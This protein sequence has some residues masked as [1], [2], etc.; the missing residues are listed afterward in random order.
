MNSA[1]TFWGFDHEAPSLVIRTATPP[2]PWAN[3]L[4]NGTYF[5]LITQTGGGYSF[6]ENCEWGRLTRWAPANYLLDQPGRWVYIRD[7]ESGE[8]WTPNFQP[9]R[10]GTD[11]ECRHGLASTQ[12]SAR[13]DGVRAAITYAVMA[14]KERRE[15]WLVEI[16]NESGRPRQLRLFPTIVWQLGH[17]FSDLGTANIMSLVNRG[18]FD[19]ELQAIRVRQEP[20]GNQPWPYEGYFTSSLPIRSWQTDQEFLLGPAG[21]WA[22]PKEIADG[23]GLSSPQ[24]IMGV[25]MVAC[26]EH[27]VTI[28]PGETLRFTVAL[29]EGTPRQALRPA[30]FAT[31]LDRTQEAMYRHYVTDT[32]EVETPS[33]ALNDI[34]NVWL[35]RQVWMNNYLGR[36]ATLY[37]EGGGEL[38][39]RNTAQDAWGLVPIDAKFA[40]DRLRHLCACQ[41]ESGKPLPGWSPLKGPS[42]HEPPSDF[43]VWL[44]MLALD[45]VKETG[46]DRFLQEVIPFFDGGTA[47]IYE[48]ILRAL[49]FLHA[50]A[51]SPR[52]LPLMGTQ[53]W[54]D[55]FDR[56]GAG[57]KGESVWLAMA[58]C[59]ALRQMKELAE[60][61]GDPKTAA[62]CE[63]LWMETREVVNRYAWDG[64]WYLIAFD[65]NGN[66][67][68]A[69]S[70]EEGSIHLNVQTWAILSGVARG[71][72]AQQLLRVI[73][74][75]LETPY[76][77]VLHAPPYTK[78]NPALG[79]IS[80]FAAGT[81]ENAA[82]FTHAGAF[83]I[84]ADLL[85]GRA[86]DAWK[87]FEQLLPNRDGR[88]FSTYLAEPHIFAEYT[89]GPGNPRFGEGA[90]T[91]LTG[92][93]DWL[94]RALLGRIIGLEPTWDG[95]RLEPQLPSAWDVVRL[96]RKWRGATYNVTV[97]RE[98]TSSG[99]IELIVDGVALAAGENLIPP[100]GA[101]GTCEVVCTVPGNWRPA[102]ART[103]AEAE[104]PKR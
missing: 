54:N 49:D 100:I 1:N 28:A 95:L 101:G 102:P 24:E 79:R 7:E 97:H 56:V 50:R 68:G 8:L 73:D 103:H 44:P 19:A 10:K 18:R 87:T 93:A 53:D 35:K 12:L 88:D 22:A 69:R 5:C 33:K 38:G 74:E 99:Q 70:N 34:A 92:S 32:Y 27:G 48:H 47:T 23:K 84:Y 86:D 9:C 85:M 39:Y 2:R 81:K 63:Q 67:V 42:T 6:F 41:R 13:H 80:A 83:K 72:R 4:T 15:D 61:V 59:F 76:G 20:W 3:Y 46:D 26:L 36:S 96:R 55:A 98:A 30:A 37:H 82:V 40:T 94:L 60:W 91:W 57:G 62:H 104:S 43:P 17:Y 52:G 89:I 11:F 90:F 21:S 58:H 29:G 31:L 71:E 75:R 66:P 16:T 64:E 45:L 78:H 25:P 51:R 14:G 77:P 65:D